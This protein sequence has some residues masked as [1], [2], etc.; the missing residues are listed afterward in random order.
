MKNKSGNVHTK[1]TTRGWILQLEW[2]GGSSEWVPLVDL[3][4]SNPVEFSEYAVDTNCK[5]SLRS[6]GGLSMYC[7]GRIKSFPKSRQDIGGKPT[8]LES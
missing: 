7:V 4:H 5:K 3:K 6:S 2:K 8:V 1:K